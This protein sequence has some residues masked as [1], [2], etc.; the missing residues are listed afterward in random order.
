MAPPDRPG[1]WQ[2]DPDRDVIIDSQVLRALAHPLRNR[3][4]ML[5]R[6][7][8]PSTATQ[9]ATRLGVNSGATSYHLRQLAGA[10]LVE[11]DADRGNARDRWWRARHRGSYLDD[12]A[13]L[14]AEPELTSAFLH[15]MAQ[16]YYDALSRAIDE[17]STLPKA[18]VD[19]SDMS[20]FTF[21]LTAKQARQLRDEIYDVMGKYRSERDDPH[22]RGSRPVKLQLQLFPRSDS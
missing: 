13:L 21:Y 3:L 1:G 15:S 8:G 4:V 19:A 16:L 17:M 10:G 18:W 11:E 7:H 5:L 2:P 14:Q 12:A 6:Q 22:P 9:L 20:D